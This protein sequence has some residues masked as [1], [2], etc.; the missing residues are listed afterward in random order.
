M[1]SAHIIS[2]IR[3]GG[4]GVDN[5]FRSFMWGA[6]PSQKLLFCYGLRVNWFWVVVFQPISPNLKG[7]NIFIKWS[8]S[9]YFPN[10]Y[11][12]WY[13]CLNIL[14]PKEKLSKDFLNI[15]R[16]LWPNCVW[17]L[18]SESESESEYVS[19]L[20]NWFGIL[21]ALR[22]VKKNDV[23]TYTVMVSF[24]LLRL[25]HPKTPVGYEHIWRN[26]NGSE[27]LGSLYPIRLMVQKSV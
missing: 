14:F 10:K 3:N 18:W 4:F 24:S 9:T 2:I 12:P 20:E 15:L 1:V 16:F 7:K 27:V 25:Y 8:G 19:W 21:P 22:H 26:L 11:V 5:V 23:K 17:S 6:H 13:L